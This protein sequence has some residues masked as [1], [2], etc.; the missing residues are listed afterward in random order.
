M[1]TGKVVC[2][3]HSSPR[4]VESSAGYADPLA[5]NV[6]VSLRPK[7]PEESMRKALSSM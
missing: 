3:S 7:L 6:P 4:E 5:D 2:A 1:E